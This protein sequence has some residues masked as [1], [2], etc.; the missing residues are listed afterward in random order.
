MK[1]IKKL[2]VKLTL[3]QEQL[4]KKVIKESKS[5]IKVR[6]DKILL[7]V[8]KK[9]DESFGFRFTK[10][11]IEKIV[12]LYK[13]Y[14][15]A[16]ARLTY[17]SLASEVI[18]RKIVETISHET[19]RK[20]LK[21]AGITAKT[22][23]DLQSAAREGHI[24]V[25]ECL[26]ENGADVRADVDLSLQF[27]A[28]NGNLGIVKFLVENG[29]DIHAYDDYALRWSAH[30]GHIKI[31]K[32]LVEKGANIHADDDCALQWAAHNENLDIVK[33]LVEKG[34]DVHAINDCALQWAAHNGKHSH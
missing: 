31:V 6:R 4:L 29:A 13:I 32:Y 3:E 5:T 17:R 16:D 12:E 15:A 11:Q 30:D 10:K 2:K 19:V 26:I 34:A 24:K 1:N 21:S 7:S 22:K 8:N 20:I 14:A 33:F 27:A 18:K 25:V 23:F 28:H 9:R